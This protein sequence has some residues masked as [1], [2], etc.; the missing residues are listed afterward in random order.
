MLT[1]IGAYLQSQGIGTLG[2]NVFLGLMPDK[3]DNCIALFEYAGSPPDLHWEGE[4]PGLQ[5]RVRNKGYAAARN[6]IEVVMG[7]N[8]HR[9]HCSKELTGARW[10]HPTIQCP[11]RSAGID[12]RDN[13]Y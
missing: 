8:S 1:E 10:P 3:P 9:F 13:N 5:V 7:R 6:K 4:Y 11:D 12:S 2:A